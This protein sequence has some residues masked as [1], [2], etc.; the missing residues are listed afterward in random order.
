M[1][2]GEQRG[3]SFWVYDWTA[4]VNRRRSPE[5]FPERRELFSE[6]ATKPL[7]ATSA[8]VP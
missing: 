2:V 7:L 8:E 4:A 3:C 5:W 6:V 1:K